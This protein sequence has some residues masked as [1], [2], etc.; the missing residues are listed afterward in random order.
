M[1]K[2]ILWFTKNLRIQDNIMI[3]WAVENEYQVMAVAFEPTNKSEQQKFYY[4]QAAYEIQEKF[5]KLNISFLILKGWPEFEI[6]KWVKSNA[7]DLVLTQDTYNTKDSKIISKL[8]EN[9]GSDQ[10]KTFYDRTLIE[11]N[12]LPFNI[13]DM[14]FVFTSFRKAIEKKLIIRKPL[15]SLYE[16]LSGFSVAIPDGAIFSDTES[17][18]QKTIFPFDIK[19]S[20]SASWKRLEEY[21][22]ETQSLSNY[23]TTRNGMLEKN[24]SSKLS[25]GLS[26]GTISAKSIYDEL[27]NYEDQFGKNESTEWFVMELFWRDYFKFL[28]LKIGHKLFSI[29]GLSQKPRSWET[30]SNLFQKWCDGETGS[31]FVDANMLEL[32]QTGWMSNRGRQNVASFLSKNLYIDWTLGADYFEKNLVDDDPESNWGNWLYVSGSGT[33]PRDRTFNIQRQ[34]DMYDP[35]SDYRNKWLKKAKP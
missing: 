23:K 19:S 12:D 2:A 9:L 25:I 35:Q 13:Q 28:S 29:N 1:K 5:K 6:P 14:P 18:P 17:D 20:E 27:K 16:K 10:I 4:L 8:K 7:V 15:P 11:I 3:N 32:N 26:L 30:D 24:D 21:F 22:F 33:D 31:D 34:A